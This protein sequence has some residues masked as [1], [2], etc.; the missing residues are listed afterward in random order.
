[1][2]IQNALAFINS[3][4]NNEEL[5]R[6]GTKLFEEAGLKGLCEKNEPSFTVEQLYA[7]F[8]QDWIV[9]KLHFSKRKHD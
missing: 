1:M 3:V 9:R 6:T 4:R 8:K 2:S 5:Q 7:A